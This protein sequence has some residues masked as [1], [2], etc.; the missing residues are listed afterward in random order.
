MYGKGVFYSRCRQVG[1]RQQ[2]SGVPLVLFE[3]SEE[4]M[5]RL[6]DQLQRQ[7]AEAARLDA[8]IAESLARLRFR[9]RQESTS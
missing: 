2:Q 1:A 6:V 5:E 4:K 9:V 8:A 3:K 7:Q